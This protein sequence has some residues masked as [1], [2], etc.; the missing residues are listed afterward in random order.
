MNYEIIE[1]KNIDK[2]LEVLEH[3]YKFYGWQV[4]KLKENKYGIYDLELDCINDIY[5]SNNLRSLIKDIIY[6]A[7][8]FYIDEYELDKDN[9]KY[10]YE[11]GKQ[12]QFL[13]FKYTSKEYKDLSSYLKEIKKMMK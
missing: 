4:I 12:L 5:I 3:F 6:R 2:D 9:L 1:L 11:Y 7:I 13:L 8:T 10:D